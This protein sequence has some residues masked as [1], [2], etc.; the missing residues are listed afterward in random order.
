MPRP[1]AI[2]AMLTL[3]G[4]CLLATKGVQ[5]RPPLTA[6]EIKAG[7]RTVSIEEEGFVDRVVDLAHRGV[8]PTSMVESTFQWARKK[9]EHRFQYFKRAMIVRAARIGVRL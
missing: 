8:L 5:A 6:E 1:R 7:L 2:V 9:A 4:V 3:V